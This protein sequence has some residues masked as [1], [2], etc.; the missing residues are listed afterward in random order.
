MYGMLSAAMKKRVMKDLED[1]YQYRREQAEGGRMNYAEKV[2]HLRRR[3]EVGIDSQETYERNREALA[4]ARAET[5]AA[6]TDS[7][8]HWG[9]ACP[10]RTTWRRRSGPRSTRSSGPSLRSTRV[11]PSTLRST[12][13]PPGWR[14]G[15]IGRA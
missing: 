11:S 12:A 5:F 10:T 3:L 13:T 1:D 6:R 14:R 4:A 8:L 15:T 9:G 2:E 7:Y